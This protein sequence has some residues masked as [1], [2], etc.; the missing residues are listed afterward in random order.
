LPGNF[1][2]AVFRAVTQLWKVRHLM[3]S[4]LLISLAAAMIGCGR[5]H[6]RSSNGWPDEFRA[7]QIRFGGLQPIQALEVYAKLTNASLEISPE[8]KSLQSGIFFTNHVDMTRPE[9]V[10]E[11]EKV[12][13][14]QAGVVIQHLNATQIVVTY[15]ASAANAPSK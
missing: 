13:R 15:D 14:S 5:S 3:K 11:L 7:E 8:V 4:L 2:L 1:T 9:V 10:A 6:P 12:L